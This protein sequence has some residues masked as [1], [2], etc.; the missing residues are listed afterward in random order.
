[1]PPKWTEAKGLAGQAKKIC[2]TV[3]FAECYHDTVGHLCLLCVIVGACIGYFLL[4][5]K[6]DYEESTYF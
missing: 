2:L 1:M 4:K 5:G 3:A 6:N